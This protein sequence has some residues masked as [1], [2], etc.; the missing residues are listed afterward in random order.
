MQSSMLYI[1]DKLDLYATLRERCQEDGSS[2]TA[3]ELAKLTGLNQRW[4]REWL[5]Q[6]ASMGILQFLQ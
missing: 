6:Q 4:L 2:M 5:A 3:V 1:G